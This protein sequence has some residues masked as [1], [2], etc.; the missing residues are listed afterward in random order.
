MTN[1]RVGADFTPFVEGPSRDPE[2]EDPATIKLARWAVG[3]LARQLDEATSRELQARDRAQRGYE[4]SPTFPWRR[5]RRAS[6]RHPPRSHAENVFE[7]RMQSAYRA[8]SAGFPTRL[9]LS[10]SHKVWWRRAFD[11]RPIL[12]TLVDKIAARRHIASRVGDGF[13]PRLYE[14]LER[15]EE[16]RP[17]NLPA[18]FVAKSTHGSGGVALCWAGDTGDFTELEPWWR[19]AYPSDDFPW[20]MV[21]KRFRQVLARDYGEEHLEWAY[22]GV[23]RRLLVEELLHGRRSRLPDEYLFFTFEGM[24]A[25]VAVAQDRF[26]QGQRVAFRTPRWEPVRSGQSLPQP[27]GNL[28]PPSRWQDML[29]LAAE[30]GRGMDMVRVDIF[31]AEEGPRVGELTVYPGGGHASFSPPEDDLIRGALWTLPHPEELTPYPEAFSNH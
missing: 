5:F 10:F 18:E 19:G 4:R 23:P 31:D 22:V 28:V 27:I 17:G 24:P 8:R 3:E 29:E 1:A 9:P 12:H 2:P 7:S 15:V 21:R 25:I 11:R 30:L 16:L 20:E 14:V 13:L 26:E 6:S